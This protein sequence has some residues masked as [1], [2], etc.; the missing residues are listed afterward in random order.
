MHLLSRKA[1]I[2]A[3]TTAS[4]ASAGLVVPASAEPAAETTV[5]TTTTSAPA[6]AEQ[7]ATSSSSKK[8]EESE[9]SKF[10]AADFFGVKGSDGKVEFA[11]VLK[12]ISTMAGVIAAVGGAAAAL[13]KIAKDFGVVKK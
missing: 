11:K 2:A 4:V 5:T 3:I 6:T 1:L 10:D 12:L 8:K 13:Y 9:S 7:N